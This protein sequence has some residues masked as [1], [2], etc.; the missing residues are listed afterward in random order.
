MTSVLGLKAKYFDALIYQRK[1]CEGRK[2][3]KTYG[4]LKPGDV[5]TLL[6]ESTGRYRDMTIVN[7]RYYK[8]L[9]DYLTSEGIE[10]CLPG[11]SSLDEAIRKYLKLWKIEEIEEYG[12]MAILF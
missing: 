10:N 9:E 5:V 2:R 4:H 1:K 12:I 8:T 11:V 6:C 3:S 7:I